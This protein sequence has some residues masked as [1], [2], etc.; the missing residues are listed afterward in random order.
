MFPLEIHPILISNNNINQTKNKLASSVLYVQC[1][2]SHGTKY[3]KLDVQMQIF[4][5]QFKHHIV[6]YLHVY[7]IQKF[8]I[9][10]FFNWNFSLE[11]IT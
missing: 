1:V 10:Y 8:T 9:I 6:V 3:N 2:D 11:P 4:F 5:K 7:F